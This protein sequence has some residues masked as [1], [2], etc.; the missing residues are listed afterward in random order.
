MWGWKGVA[1]FPPLGAL[2]AQA[3]GANLGQ[4]DF[5]GK[6]FVGKAENAEPVFRAFAEAHKPR[7]APTQNGM[8]PT[9]G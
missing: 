4:L 8:H 5:A 7:F 9:W 1:I 3:R 2:A 6:V